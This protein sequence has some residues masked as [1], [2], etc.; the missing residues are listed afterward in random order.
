MIN[1][2]RVIEAL[3]VLKEYG[4]GETF[5]GVEGSDL[6]KRSDE[7]INAARG[8]LLLDIKDMLDELTELGFSNKIISDGDQF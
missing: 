2:T 4:H 8:V 7:I 1:R 5:K 6:D 3:D